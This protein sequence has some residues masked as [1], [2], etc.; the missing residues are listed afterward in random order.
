M[1]VKAKGKNKMKIENLTDKSQLFLCLLEKKCFQ[2]GLK[3]KETLGVK[4][5]Q[6]A[7]GY[8]IHIR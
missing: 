7:D 4:L 6:M 3:K 2:F 5:C 8:T 1:H